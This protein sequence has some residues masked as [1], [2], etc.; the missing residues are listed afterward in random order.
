MAQGDTNRVE[1]TLVHEFDEEPDLGQ[2]QRAL[3]WD[4]ANTFVI[5]KGVPTPSSRCEQRVISLEHW[6]DRRDGDLF[7]PGETHKPSQWLLHFRYKC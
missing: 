2:I 1:S 7:E 6:I 4:R 3:A 5:H